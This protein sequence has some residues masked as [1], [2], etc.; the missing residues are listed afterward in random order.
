M[1]AGRH[2]REGETLEQWCRDRE[3]RLESAFCLSSYDVECMQNSR[4][5]YNITGL[6]GQIKNILFNVMEMGW[7]VLENFKH[8]WSCTGEN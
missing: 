7:R 1:G 2:S 8:D 3:V 5:G 6:E 4:W